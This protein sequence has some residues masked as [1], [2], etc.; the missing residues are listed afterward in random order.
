MEQPNQSSDW[1]SEDMVQW[2]TFLR[3]RAGQRLFTRAAESAPA[4]MAK[5]ET[6]EIL[7]RNGM[8]IGFGLAMQAIL[9][10]A[11]PPPKVEAPPSEY[12]PLTDDAAW[13]DGQTI[14]TS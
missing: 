10:L 4:L 5:G 13:A 2:S 1:D 6:N 9:A 3:S 11:F 7:I 8:A 14:K 12:P